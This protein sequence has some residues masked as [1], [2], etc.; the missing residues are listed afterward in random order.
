MVEVCIGVYEKDMLQLKRTN[1]LTHLLL[2]TQTTIQVCAEDRT[3]SSNHIGVYKNTAYTANEYSIS[4]KLYEVDG[5]QVSP[6]QTSP[7]LNHGSWA[8]ILSSNRH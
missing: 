4:Q 6:Q 3:S 1:I 8:S 5:Q 2:Q 7:L